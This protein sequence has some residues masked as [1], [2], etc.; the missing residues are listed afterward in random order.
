M[1]K[2]AY[3]LRISDWS[4]DVCSSD[5]RAPVRSCGNCGGASTTSAIPRLPPRA[6]HHHPALT[7]PG[8][9]P[10]SPAHLRDNPAMDTQAHDGDALVV[11]GKTYRSRLLTGTGKFKD[12][13]ETG[14]ATEAAGSEIVTVAIRR[15]NL[16]QNPG[17]PNLL[18]VLPP[19]RYTILPNPAGCYTAEDAV[20]TCRPAPELLACHPL[21]KLEV[22]C[23]QEA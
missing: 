8:E 6:R 20:R 1:R 23:D 17:E 4:S 18:D 7:R 22:R 14:A 5:L 3:E 16:G 15:S 2:T 19:D 11:A 10:E 12:L 21:A 13:D 9:T